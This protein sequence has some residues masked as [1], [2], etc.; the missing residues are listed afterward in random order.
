MNYHLVEAKNSKSPTYF[1]ENESLKIGAELYDFLREKIALMPMVR[2]CLHSKS[3]ELTQ[4]MIIAITPEAKIEFHK[5]LH[6]EK[7]Y[8]IIKG[9]MLFE[10][11]DQKALTLE[12]GE[13]LKLQK[14][15]FARMSAISHYCI[16]QEIVA[17]PFNS[18]DTVY[19]Y[20]V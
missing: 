18:E 12:A 4:M 8:Q 6:K 19:E 15:T 17:G 7:M 13:L 14:S 3:A 10:I 11:K 1:I 16:Y 9:E 5:N 20:V 2:I